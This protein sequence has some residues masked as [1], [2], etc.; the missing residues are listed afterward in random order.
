MLVG[1]GELGDEDGEE[2]DVDDDGKHDHQKHP[3]CLKVVVGGRREVQKVLEEVHRRHVKL[4]KPRLLER[5]ESSGKGDEDDAHQDHEA[6]DVAEEL[7]DRVGE[8]S[9]A[10]GDDERLN[11]LPPH[12]DGRDSRH[13]HQD[14]NLVVLRHGPRHGRRR[15]FDL[16]PP[17]RGHALACCRER[18]KEETKHGNVSCEVPRIG[19]KPRKID[20]KSEDPQ[21]DRLAGHALFDDEEGHEEAHDRG[22]DPAQDARVVA[23]QLAV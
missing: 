6:R 22:Q 20:R 4:L 9:Q 10:G 23:R 14:V 13:H 1:E 15:V 7:S 21:G 3:Q 19:E 8:G 11:Q 17:V 5:G 18:R 16:G 12:A 2:A